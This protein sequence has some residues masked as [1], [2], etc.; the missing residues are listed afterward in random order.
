MDPVDDKEVEQQGE[1]EKEE[2]EED[3]RAEAEAEGSEAEEEEEEEEDEDEEDEESDDEEDEEDEDSDDDVDQGPMIAVT[4]PG[5]DAL[6]AGR[7]IQISV[8]GPSPLDWWA[9]VCS[10]ILAK[11]LGEAVVRRHDPPSPSPLSIF[12]DPARFERGHVIV[13]EI[14]L[15]GIYSGGHKYSL[16]SLFSTIGSILKTVWDLPHSAGRDAQL[17]A[18]DK[19][20][21]FGF[22]EAEAAHNLLLKSPPGQVQAH[23]TAFSEG[24]AVTSP[25]SRFTRPS[26]GSKRRAKTLLTIL[27]QVR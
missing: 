20:V 18:I 11:R 24:G 27:V 22:Q 2:E 14:L 19:A 8:V 6:S 26:R 3:A 7:V 9:D 15:H 12:R 13:E 10:P 21:T 16:R 17:L 1:N 25:F 5:R 4:V 23:L